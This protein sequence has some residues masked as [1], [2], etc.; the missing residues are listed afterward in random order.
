MPINYRSIMGSINDPTPNHFVKSYYEKDEI[1]GQYFYTL[2][3][4][5]LMVIG[6]EM[7]TVGIVQVYIF[8]IKLQ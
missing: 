6:S 8:L 2:Y 5:L 1:Y 3:S 4:I 7:G